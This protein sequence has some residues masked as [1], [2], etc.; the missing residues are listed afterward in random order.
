MK[1][2]F[3]GLWVVAILLVINVTRHEQ[4]SII[5]Y[6]S[7]EQYRGEELQNQLNEEFP[8]ENILVMYLPTAKSAAKIMV[9]GD[10]TDADIVVGLESS[11]MDKIQGSL[12]DLSGIETPAYVE[13]FATEDNDNQYITW[14]KQ[15]GSFVINTDVM[16]RHNLPI[17][18]TY[19]ELLDP[20][21]KGV[22]AMPDPKSSGTGYFFYK[23][24]VNERGTEEALAYID[25]LAKNVK[26]FTESG[27]G[28]IKLLIQEE[29]GVGLALTFQA[30]EQINAG[31]PF[32][33][34]FP[35]EGSP[36]SLTAT[37]LIKG[38]EDNELIQEVFHYITNDF[39]IYDK[40]HFS[41]ETI[42]V[43]QEIAMENYPENIKYADMEGIKEIEEKERLLKLWKY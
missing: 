20:M 32:E 30:V 14:E 16:E 13:G 24:L 40:A 25:E 27:S 29:I 7:L 36:Y 19:D 34:I 39:L 21:Y 5:I 43:D 28:P 4:G 12:A 18:T 9:E 8:D 26:A 3:I 33:I 38:R 23:S 42:L 41:P 35:E 6:S 11:Y 22:I 31:S 2:I 37:G 15:A 1:K 10:N 17:P